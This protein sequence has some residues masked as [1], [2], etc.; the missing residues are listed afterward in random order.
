MCHCLTCQ[1]IENSTWFSLFLICSY[2]VV[3]L[4]IFGERNSVNIER[5]AIWKKH[6]LKKR[7]FI[8]RHFQIISFQGRNTKTKLMGVCFFP[9]FF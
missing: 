3:A 6:V 2:N 1:D 4:H 9:F 8:N 7:T 5:Y